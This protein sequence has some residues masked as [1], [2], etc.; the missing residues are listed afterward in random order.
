MTATESRD[1]NGAP[2]L[3]ASDASFPELV[4]DRVLGGLSKSTE[5][6]DTGQTLLLSREKPGAS[7][8]IL[9]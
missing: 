5:L 4:G 2:R 7:E 8:L 6:L 9:M 1:T 3:R